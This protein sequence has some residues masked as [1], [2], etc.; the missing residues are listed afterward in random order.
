MRPDGVRCPD[1]REQV[2][3]TGPFSGTGV[4]SLVGLLALDTQKLSPTGT[5]V[6]DKKQTWIFK[7][8]KQGRN[9]KIQ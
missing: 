5:D 3:G 4:L 6:V 1:G 9:P 2:P 8:K 7:L